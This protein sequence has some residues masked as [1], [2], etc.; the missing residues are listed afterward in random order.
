MQEDR[1]PKVGDLDVSIRP[2]EQILRL[3]IAVEYVV[4][5][6]VLETPS[7]LRKGVLAKAF[8]VN[9]WTLQND[10]SEVTTLHKF[11]EYPDSV[12][13]FK[14]LFTLDNMFTSKCIDQTALINDTLSFNLTHSCVLQSIF[15][16]VCD[17]FASKNRTHSASSDFLNNLIEVSRIQIFDVNSLGDE[18]LDLAE[19]SQS[20]H[21]FFGLH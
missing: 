19:R 9:V 2:T 6:H 14:Y 10:V 12:F 5:M 13:A 15:I 4:G 11:E 18:L 7:H 16:T 21:F 20:I 3:D 8:T 1:K 17:A